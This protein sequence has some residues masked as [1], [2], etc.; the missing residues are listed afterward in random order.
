MEIMGGA[1]TFDIPDSMQFKPEK[2]IG[3]STSSSS[4]GNQI[5]SNVVNT[6]SSPFGIGII[7]SIF[8]IALLVFLS[9][10]LRK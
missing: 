2:Y 5:L 3:D 10:Y 7:V 1:L 4:S 6:V 9:K 8:V